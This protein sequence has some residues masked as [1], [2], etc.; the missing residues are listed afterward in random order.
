MTTLALLTELCRQGIKFIDEG[1]RLRVA[2]PKGVVLS[3]TIKDEIRRRKEEIFD[4]LRTGGDAIQ[5]TSEVFSGT[6]TIEAD[7]DF[8]TCTRCAR[9]EWWISRYGMKV[10]EHCF[11]PSTSAVVVARVEAPCKRKDAV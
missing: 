1:D 10:C 9:D 8:G 2:S 4:R 7:T 5:D 11:P 3:D 6:V